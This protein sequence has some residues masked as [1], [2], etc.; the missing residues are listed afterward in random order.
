VDKVFERARKAIDPKTKGE[1]TWVSREK[2]DS[3]GVQFIAPT[4]IRCVMLSKPPKKSA[5]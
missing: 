1:W 3:P 4:H 2:G 5:A